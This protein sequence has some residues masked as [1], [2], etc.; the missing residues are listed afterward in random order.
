MAP[1]GAPMSAQYNNSRRGITKS[2]TEKRKRTEG[3]LS[4]KE[5]A[6]NIQSVYR[7]YVSREEVESLRD[8]TDAARYLTKRRS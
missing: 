7:G 4:E 8:D 2:T 6:T 3:S 5:A 1:P